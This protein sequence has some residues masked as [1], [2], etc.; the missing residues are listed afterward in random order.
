MTRIGRIPGLA[1]LA[2]L[3]L[4]TACKQ[5]PSDAFD[6]RPVGTLEDVAAL[7]SRDDLNVVFV[8][9]DTL[10]SDRM[11]S[12]GYERATTP[13]LDYFAARG[14]R[15][16]DHRAQSS[17][18]KTSMA[19]LWTGLYPQRT[20][21]LTYND[22]L[23]PAARVPAEIFK[24]AGYFTAGIWRNGWVAPNFGFD[25]GFDYY[26]TPNAR[27]APQAL[28]QKPIAGRIDGTDIDA[29]YTAI[30]LMRANRDRRFFLY[31]HLMDVHQYISTEETAIFGHTY[32]DAY[33][34]AV[35]WTDEQIGELMAEL[36]RLSLHDRT[37]VVFT[38]DHGEAFGEHGSEGHARDVHHEVVVT[39]F[40]LSFP[41][42]LDPGIVVSQ[43]TENVDVWPTVFELLG[44]P[45]FDEAD[46]KSR[47]GWLTGDRSAESAPVS[48]SHLDRSWGQPKMEPNPLIGVQEGQYRLLHDVNHPEKDLLFDVASDPLERRNVAAEVPDAL[49]KLQDRAKLYLEGR[50]PWDGGAPEIELDDLSLRQLRALGYSIDE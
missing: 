35:R 16:A 15:F 7:A 13:V 23:A 47:A 2:A 8:L 30:E 3:V 50:T 43:R 14:L 9:I 4:G 33:D 18:T 29:I 1:L 11:G 32:S 38:S 25:Q 27:L 37:L 42:K 10:R 6:T 12:Y 22:T 28:R 45:G 17:W 5:E 46:G 36:F 24:E 20:D 21:V 39:P 49:A 41:F 40:I 44:L 31:M 19:S 34:N 26:V 48:I